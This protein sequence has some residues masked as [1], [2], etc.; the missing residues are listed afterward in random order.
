ML[1]E[2]RASR[3]L[4]GNTVYRSR[5]PEPSPYVNSS[6]ASKIGSNIYE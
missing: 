3:H 6:T 5:M 1:S 2:P 4:K